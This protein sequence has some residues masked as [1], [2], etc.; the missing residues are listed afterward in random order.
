MEGAGG[1]RSAYAETTEAR[2]QLAGG[3]AGEGDREHVRGI[4]EPLARLPGDA[5]GEHAGL[6]RARAGEDRERQRRGW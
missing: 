5:T 3:L 4:D 2:A 6:A 1:D